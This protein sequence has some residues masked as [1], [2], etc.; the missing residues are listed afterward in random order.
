MQI[1]FMFRLRNIL[2]KKFQAQTDTHSF[3]F[4]IYI[5]YIGTNG[6]T[7]IRVKEFLS[8]NRYERIVKGN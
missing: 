7:K 2:S 6:N 4:T 5:A 8:T 1:A 3:S